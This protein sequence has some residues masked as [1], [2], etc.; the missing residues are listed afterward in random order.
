[1]RISIISP[2]PT[3]RAG[4]TALAHEQPGWEVASASGP[5][6]LV[7]GATGA[8][9]IPAEPATALDVALIDLEAGFEAEA[10]AEWVEALRPRSGVVALGAIE[11]PGA[12]RGA[13]E[14]A[15][16]QTAELA[17]LVATDGLGFGALPRDA[18]TDEIVAAV[19]AAASGLTA[20]DRGLALEA[21][22][23]LA[24]RARAEPVSEP[25]EPL[26]TREREVLQLLAQGIPNKQIAQRLSISEHTVKFHV[27]AI[28][29]KLGAAS[30]TEAVTTAARRGLLLL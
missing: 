30:R 4:L 19:T 23:G 18:A 12:G 1:M 26:T 6:A 3:V 21:F 9:A 10:V 11:S 28:M 25:T 8:D 14:R 17:R 22:A 2:Y 16:S 29:T 15:L 5:A 7:T 24:R 20:L 13:R 27:S